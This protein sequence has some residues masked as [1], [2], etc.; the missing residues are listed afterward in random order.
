MNV[1]SR[2]CTKME[3]QDNSL[4]CCVDNLS[5]LL[6]HDD[7]M[8]SDGALRCF[9]SLADRFA[10]RDV[11][12]APLADKG[13]KDYLVS[14]LSNCGKGHLPLSTA[15]SGLGGSNS[16]NSKNSSISTV[17]SLLSTLCR[18][19]PKITHDLVRSELL[20]AIE[21]MLIL[22]LIKYNNLRTIFYR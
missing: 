16:D 14:K 11:D 5:V 19:S 17:I 10:R 4:E 1:V 6:K 22:N 12:P 20:D 18:G 7:A 15:P 13:L 9:A 8:V 3:A 21:V 2:L